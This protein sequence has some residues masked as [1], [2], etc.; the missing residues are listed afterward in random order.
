MPAWLHS[1]RSARAVV[2][3]ATVGFFGELHPAEAEGRKLKQRVLVAELWLDRLFRQDLRQPSVRELSRFQPV[4]R[5]F[6]VLMPQTVAW[7]AVAAAIEALAIPEMQ[8]FAAKEVMREGK[9]IPAGQYSLLLGVIFQAQERT[10]REE[11][12]QSWSQQV[13]G[14]LELLG[15]A[16]RG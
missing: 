5:D 13:I 15:A 3:G 14:A 7:A 4:R 9:Q 12:V 10:L 11:E 2:D 16:L 8:S 6:S 1:G